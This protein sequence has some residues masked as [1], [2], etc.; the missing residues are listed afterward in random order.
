MPWLLPVLLTALLLLLPACS[1]TRTTNTARTG[2]EQILVSN[3]IDRTL[4]QTPL[5]PVAGRKVY[6]EDKYLDCVDKGYL[7]ASLRQRLLQEGALLTTKPEDS[8][9]TVEARTGGV[10]TDDSDTFVGVP[11]ITLPAP[12]PF[13]MP[14]V[15][16]YEKFSQFGTAKIGLVAFETTSGKLLFDS[17]RHIAR[18]D[19]SRW[20]FLG[21]GPFRSGSARSELENAAQGGTVRTASYEESN[22]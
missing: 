6:L 12:V 16:L 11:G 18:S 8:E 21:I 13:E 19:D 3:A 7:V 17:G 15:R 20:A 22:R 14:E 2:V 10:G 4:D 9:I 1:T 5:P